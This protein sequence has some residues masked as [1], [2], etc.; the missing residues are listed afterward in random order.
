MQVVQR[1]SMVE[2]PARQVVDRPGQ[3]LWGELDNPLTVRVATKSAWR[4]AV[5]DAVAHGGPGGVPAGERGRRALGDDA[6]G[7][8]YGDRSARYCALST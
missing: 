5:R 1:E 4:G 2:C 8:D 7:R 6:A 3:I